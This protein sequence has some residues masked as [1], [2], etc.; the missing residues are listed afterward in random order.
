MKSCGAKFIDQTN[1]FVGG[2]PELGVVK[3]IELEL[4]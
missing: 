3:L 4:F 1:E 2:L